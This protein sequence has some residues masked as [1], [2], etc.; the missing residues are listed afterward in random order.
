MPLPGGKAAYSTHLCCRAR[1]LP[2]AT[3]AHAET[4]PPLLRPSSHP[5][6]YRLLLSGAGGL[7]GVDAL[8]NHASFLHPQYQT[9]ED[10]PGGVEHM[11]E[12]QQVGGWV[13]GLGWFTGNTAQTAGTFP[14]VLTRC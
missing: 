1:P 5:R 4:P 12:A 11:A 14:H 9:L 8:L 2:F 7:R 6:R 10:I 13:L 3:P